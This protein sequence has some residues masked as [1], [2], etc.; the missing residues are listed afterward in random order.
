M[1]RAFAIDVLACPRCGGRLRVIATVEDLVAVRQILTAPRA[2][3]PLG[4]ARRLVLP[5]SRP[6]T[7]SREGRSTSEVAAADRASPRSPRPHRTTPK[8]RTR[9]IP[10]GAV[11]DTPRA[12]GAGLGPREAVRMS[13]TRRRARGAARGRRVRPIRRDGGRRAQ[14]APQPVPRSQARLQRPGGLSDNGEVHSPWVTLGPAH[15]LAHG[16]PPRGGVNGRR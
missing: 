11:L 4:P 10:L 1:R 6:D 12:G 13:T 5:P 3:Q 9:R 2:A 7:W 15:R 16:P 8:S 14:G